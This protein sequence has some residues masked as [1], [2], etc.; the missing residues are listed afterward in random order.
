MSRVSS[1]KLVRNKGMIANAVKHFEGKEVEVI[2]K[3][4]RKYRSSPQNAYLLWSN[5]SNV[6][7]CYL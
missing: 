6:S 1:G 5:N 3:M 2:I 4:K 7:K